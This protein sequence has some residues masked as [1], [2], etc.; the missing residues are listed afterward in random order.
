MAEITNVLHALDTFIDIDIKPDEQM[1][2]LVSE[3]VSSMLQLTRRILEGV[4]TRMNCLKFYLVCEALF[5]VKLYISFSID[6]EL[7]VNCD[8]T[9]V[10]QFL[11]FK[12]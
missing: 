6:R 4:L 5:K 9:R 8:Q 7:C 12:F 3:G 2:M 10:N 1:K 11:G